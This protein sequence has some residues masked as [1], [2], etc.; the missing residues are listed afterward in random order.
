MFYLHPSRSEA[1]HGGGSGPA[2]SYSLRCQRRAASDARALPSASDTLPR[3]HCGAVSV[4][5]AALASDTL[6]PSLRGGFTAGLSV[7][8]APSPV[9]LTV[10]PLS[11]TR[12]ALA[13]DTLEPCCERRCAPLRAASDAARRRRFP[14]RA[15]GDRPAGDSPSL[16]YVPPWNE[17]IIWVLGY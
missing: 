6:E 16:H 14:P 1:R 11:V 10:T 9:T 17:G 3:L 13:R 15:A 4:T 2:R 12:A 5:R 7:S 8:L